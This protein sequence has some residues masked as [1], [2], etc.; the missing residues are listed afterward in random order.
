MWVGNRRSYGVLRSTSIENEDE[1]ED[2]MKMKM[3]LALCDCNGY[4]GEALKTKYV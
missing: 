3:K 2:E 1:D 4:L